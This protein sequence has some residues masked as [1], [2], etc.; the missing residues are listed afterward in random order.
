[1]SETL[2]ELELNDISL[3]DLRKGYN[4]F[5]TENAKLGK[6]IVRFNDKCVKIRRNLE[7]EIAK[8][9]DHIQNEID[10]STELEIC[11]AELKAENATL[12]ESVD[13]FV[14]QSDDRNLLH[15][16]TMEL[17]VENANLRDAL[18]FISCD[19]DGLGTCPKCGGE[20]G[21]VHPR[22]SEELLRAVANDALK[23]T[24]D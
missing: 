16:K 20:H 4:E 12:R 8:L 5:R 13:R 6:D 23:G 22:S 2:T 19:W 1:M 3:R 10:N 24:N 15:V 21:A 7:A 18:T 9:R 14:E 11:V 17:E